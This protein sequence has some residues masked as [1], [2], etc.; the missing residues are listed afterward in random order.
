MSLIL[1]LIVFAGGASVMVLELVGSRIL[2]P[3][4]GTSL[5]VWTSLIGLILG[6]LSLGYFVGGKLADAKPSYRSLAF[7]L[8]ISAAGIAAI[9]PAEY[10]IA[11]PL[12]K[13][14]NNIV[15]A[16]AIAGLILFAL[17]SFFMA[18]ITPL[19]VRLRLET[20][21]HRGSVVGNL[22]A[23]STAGSII[24]TFLAGYLLIPK[25][26]HTAVLVVLAI[27]ML[28]MSLLAILKARVRIAGWIGLAVLAYAI[29]LSYLYLQIRLIQSLG[30]INEIDTAY[31]RV[32][33]TKTRDQTTRE[34]VLLLGTGQ[35][36]RYIQS[37]MSLTD[38]DKLMSEYTK[39]YR[40]IDAFIP[41]EKRVLML[42]GGG[43]AYPREF[44]R[45]HKG[46][47]M[48]V[49]EI[50]P[51]ITQIA[52]EYFHLGD[53]FR[54]RIYDEDG[55][56]FTSQEHYGYD[57]V[58]MDMFAGG[59][60]IPWHTVTVEAFKQINNI[61][62]PDGLII[63]NAISALEGPKS[64]PLAVL[65][66]TMKKVF[67]DVL[68]FAVGNP[69]DKSNLQ[70]V[71]L[72]SGRRQ[73]GETLIENTVDTRELWQNAVYDYRPVTRDVNT[74]DK[75]ILEYANLRAMGV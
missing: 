25:F 4:V 49:V 26:G 11:A 54:L 58:L 35:N 46:S 64:Y 45:I 61:I 15:T 1:E 29:F 16:A 3:Y 41:G 31:N 56:R 36:S 2:A 18:M 65:Y 75:P 8:F 47:F 32:W 5:Y 22:T 50:D 68:V 37:A 14:I 57:A 19:A 60:D 27:L 44:I 53:D 69:M 17:P 63:M 23:L 30:H 33:V 24:G 67:P 52:H 13:N 40:L 20:F 9:K 71:M 73:F 39:Y 66:N 28:V 12:I 59:N 51:G 34:E 6:S 21:A 42:G 7:V 62:D 10:F 43:Y 74:D 55:R 70:N 38:P 72:V 48:D